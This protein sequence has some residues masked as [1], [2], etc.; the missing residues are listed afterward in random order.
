[1]SHVQTYESANYREEVWWYYG[2][3]REHSAEAFT[4]RN[5][6]LVSHYQ[7]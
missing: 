3:Q 2:L 6:R 5:G 1:M 7:S 4:F